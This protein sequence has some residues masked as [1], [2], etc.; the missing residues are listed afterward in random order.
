MLISI[1]ETIERMYFARKH[2]E[3][4]VELGPDPIWKKADEISNKN[5]R[6]WCSHNYGDGTGNLN[7]EDK[8]QGLGIPNGGFFSSIYKTWKTALPHLEKICDGFDEVLIDRDAWTPHPVPSRYYNEPS[9]EPPPAPVYEVF[10]PLSDY[11]TTL[12]KLRKA[13]N[14][15]HEDVSYLY[16]GT[17]NILDRV[18]EIRMKKDVQLHNCLSKTLL[19]SPP[20]PVEDLAE[21]EEEL[22]NS[23]W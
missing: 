21:V 13:I 15:M 22:S 18:A 20:S 12:P 3:R 5:V 16:E 1:T 9:L 6:N 4:Q 19:D 23:N 7:Y 11:D 10:D 8:F 17:G 14:K 2:R